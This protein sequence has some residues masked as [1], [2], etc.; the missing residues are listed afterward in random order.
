LKRFDNIRSSLTDVEIKSAK[1]SSEELMNRFGLLTTTL[2]LGLIANLLL[3][4]E[5]LS[6]GLLR[7]IGV[8]LVTLEGAFLLSSVISI[9]KANK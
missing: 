8:R 2:T 6:S 3:T 4:G 1:S 9:L 7:E 5:D